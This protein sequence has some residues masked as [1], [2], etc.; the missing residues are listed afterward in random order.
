MLPAAVKNTQG[1]NAQASSKAAS[2]PRGGG[3][4][5]IGV[6]R[7]ASASQATGSSTDHG[8]VAPA[9]NI[10]MVPYGYLCAWP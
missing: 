9:A 7:L 3:A 5:L 1:A 10:Q 6:W 2:S 8:S 4:R